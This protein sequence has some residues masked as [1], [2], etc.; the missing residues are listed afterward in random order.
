MEPIEQRFSNHHEQRPPR[1]TATKV[2]AAAMPGWVWRM[3]ISQGIQYL[4]T[5]IAGPEGP[6]PDPGSGSHG[7]SGQEGSGGGGGAGGASG[8]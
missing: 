3:A 6:D 4:A 1:A 2:W 8:N 7:A 5:H